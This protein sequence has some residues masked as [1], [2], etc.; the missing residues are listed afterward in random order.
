MMEKFA[1]DEKL[2]QMNEQKRRMKEC[3]HR[4]EVKKLFFKNSNKFY[5]KFQYFFFLI[6]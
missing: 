1:A 2:E 5:F 6:G 4:K 3:I